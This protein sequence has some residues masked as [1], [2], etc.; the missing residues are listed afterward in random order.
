MRITTAKGLL[1]AGNYSQMQKILTKA[2][3]NKHI[4]CELFLVSLH[5]AEELLTIK[6]VFGSELDT[7]LKELITKFVDVTQEPQVRVTPTSRYFRS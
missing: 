1:F 5:F 6:T 3:R 7:K 2:A 4:E